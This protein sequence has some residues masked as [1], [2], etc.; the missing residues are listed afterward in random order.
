MDIPAPTSATRWAPLDPSSAAELF[1]RAPVRWWLSGGTALD[2]WL[3]RAVQER[4]RTSVS[5][6]RHDLAV[7]LDVL[8]AGLSA[9][10]PAEA[11]DGCWQ[12]VSAMDEDADLQR[13]WIHDDGA[14]VW[15]LQ[16]NVEDGAERAWMYR[17]DPRLQLPWDV[18]VLD[19]AGLPTGAPEVQLIWKAL[20]PTPEDDADKDAVLPRLS[21]DARARWERALLSIHPHSSWAIHVRSPVFPAKASWRG[22]G[23]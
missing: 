10:A 6:I 21:E 16:V 13:V 8:P 23:R 9:W 14:G 22:R 7:L 2:H 20:R 5:T 18:A 1:A 11:G 4:P 19:I 3:G 12:K 17:R 15:T